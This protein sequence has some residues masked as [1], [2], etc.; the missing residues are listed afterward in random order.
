MHPFDFAS[1]TPEKSPKPVFL[2]MR[3]RCAAD[4][5]RMRGDEYRRALNYREAI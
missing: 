3:G 2:Q 5:R 4:A 1:D